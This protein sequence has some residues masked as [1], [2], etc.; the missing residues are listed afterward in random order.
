MNVTHLFKTCPPQ[1]PFLLVERKRR[2]DWYDSGGRAVMWL[3]VRLPGRLAWVCQACSIL[4][5]LSPSV[6]F[7]W[8]HSGVRLLHLLFPVAE[9]A[10][11]AAFSFLKAW[12][13]T[14]VPLDI[15]T[16]HAL[17]ST[18]GWWQGR[19][20]SSESHVWVSPSA[21]VILTTW[22]T[23]RRVS[24]QLLLH[25]WITMTEQQMGKQPRFPISTSSLKELLGGLSAVVYN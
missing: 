21:T 4:A 13:Q 25:F 15:W 20:L 1:L 6:G 7:K 2:W 19:R 10:V 16:P 5:M 12:V 18:L 3:W 22:S 8:L 11:Q 23:V 24:H 17:L 14:G 9:W